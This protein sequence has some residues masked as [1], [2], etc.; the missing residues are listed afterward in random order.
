MLFF[1]SCHVFFR[2]LAEMCFRTIMKLPQKAGSRTWTCSFGTSVTLPWVTVC[3]TAQRI[4]SFEHFWILWWGCLSVLTRFLR[5]CIKLMNSNEKPLG[6]VMRGS[7]P[8]PRG[9]CSSSRQVWMVEGFHT[10]LILCV[11]GAIHLHS[12][13]GPP[14][15]GFFSWAQK[16]WMSQLFYIFPILCVTGA[17]NLHSALG[18]PSEFLGF[19][20]IR[21]CG[22]LEI[23]EFL[24]KNIKSIKKYKKI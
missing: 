13:W 4:G 5:T 1:D 10:F 23:K 6:I 22:N 21:K 15:D 11:T 3:S 14:S 19:P 16:V 20:E 8:L 17:M 2:F 7:L 18:R 9:I 12:A 24:C